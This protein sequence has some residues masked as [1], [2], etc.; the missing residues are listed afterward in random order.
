MKTLFLMLVSGL[1]FL[2]SYNQTQSPKIV[3]EKETH[4]FG[5]IKEEA[6]PVSYDFVFTNTGSQPLIIQTVKTSCGCTTPEWTK[7]PVLPGKKG[8]IRATYNPAGRPGPFNKSITVT[9]NAE[10]NTV[11]LFIKGNVTPKPKTIE[12]D[13]PIQ[14]GD[15]RLKTNHLAFM[16]TYIGKLKTDSIPVYN[17]SDKEVK[18][19][20]TGIPSHISIKTVPESLKPKQKGDIIITYDAAKKQDYGFV[21]DRFQ[22]LINNESPSNNTITVSAKILDDFSS[23]TPEQKAN[24]PKAVFETLEYNF[25]T[26]KDGDVVEYNFKLKNEGKSDLIIRKVKASC[27][28]TAVEPKEKIIKPGQSTS[29]YSKFD[30]RG[31]VGRQ[32]KTITV[33]TND[34]N[35]AEITLR[36]VGDVS[37][38]EDEQQ[39][40]ATGNK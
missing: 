27:G 2:S 18:L 6:G 8:F 35:N 16:D 23:L 22:L 37:K 38:K 40:N 26:I 34:P 24:A 20:Y 19:S 11:T 10:N 15:I 3:F 1:I 39:Q 17:S 12:D 28:C 30:S 33:I 25:G 36:I 4:D 14:V 21:S 13:Y 5:T 32:F 9:S 29:I 31:R 7:D